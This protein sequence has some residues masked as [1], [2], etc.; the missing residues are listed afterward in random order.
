MQKGDRCA[1]MLQNSPAFLISWLGIARIEAIE[2]SINTSLRGD[3]FAYILNQALNF[4]FYYKSIGRK[5][6]AKGKCS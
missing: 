1:V 2:V 6:Y 3:L 5:L 4:N